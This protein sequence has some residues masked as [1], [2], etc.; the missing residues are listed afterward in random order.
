MICSFW[1]LVL[2]AVHVGCSCMHLGHSF[3]LVGSQMQRS[4]IN[5]KAGHLSRL[6]AHLALPFEAVLGLVWNFLPLTLLII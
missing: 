2:H 3:A 4:L 6:S 1:V 5:C